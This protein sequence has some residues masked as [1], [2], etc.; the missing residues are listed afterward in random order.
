MKT[1]KK[2]KKKKKKITSLNYVHQVLLAMLPI[3]QIA[4]RF[5]FVHSNY[6]IYVWTVKCLT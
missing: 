1:L 2:K 5:I 4:H 3:L 6:T